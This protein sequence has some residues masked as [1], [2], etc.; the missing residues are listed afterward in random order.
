[1]VKN[2]YITMKNTTRKKILG[3]TEKKERDI[4]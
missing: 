2:E 1:M 4:S 3:G